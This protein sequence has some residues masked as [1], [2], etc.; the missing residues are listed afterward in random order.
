MHHD[1]NVGDIIN[2]KGIDYEVVDV[3]MTHQAMLMREKL[4]AFVIFKEKAGVI[5]KERC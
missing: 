2:D 3:D 1:Y 4:S 5:S